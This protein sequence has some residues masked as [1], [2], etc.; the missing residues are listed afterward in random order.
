VKKILGLATMALLCAALGGGALV[1]AGEGH[2]CGGKAEATSAHADHHCNMSAEACAQEMQKTLSTRGWLGLSMD[3]GDESSMAITK[4][5]PGSPAEKAG[6]QVGDKLVSIN[7]VAVND[8]NEEKIH[9]M[10]KKAKIGDQV[11]YVVSRDSQNTTL[12]ATLAQMPQDAI[13]EAI[14]QHMKTD[15]QMAKN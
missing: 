1:L 2:D 7:G 10:L 5:Y 15:H 11:T 6:F 8:E 14:E 12:K 9:G 4:V 13:A 3:P